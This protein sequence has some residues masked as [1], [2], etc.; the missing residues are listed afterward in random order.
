MG[1]KLALNLFSD[2]VQGMDWDRQA[3]QASAEVSR[4]LRSYPDD[5]LE[6]L[7]REGNHGIGADAPVLI[8]EILGIA[9]LA[10]FGIPA[11]H[12]KIRET[13]EEWK[14]IAT[15]ARKV[16]SWISSR[17]PVI[18]HSIEVAFYHLLL[19]LDRDIPVGELSLMHATEILGKADAPAPSFD[20]APMVYYLFVFRH[21]DEWLH[22]IVLDCHLRIHV[23]KVLPLDPRFAR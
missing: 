2:P 4:T 23:Q 11:F 22:L 6:F 15:T 14:R 1:F 16:V 9:S 17:F 12:K 10:F 3:A 18:S 8:L 5:T 19:E 13:I 7:I 21:A 20:S